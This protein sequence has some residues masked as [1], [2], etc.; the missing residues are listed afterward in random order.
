M[1]VSRSWILEFVF[2]VGREIGFYICKKTFKPFFVLGDQL[3]PWK[4][5]SDLISCILVISRKGQNSE[6]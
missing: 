1:E 4:E 5:G 6:T 3:V 2:G